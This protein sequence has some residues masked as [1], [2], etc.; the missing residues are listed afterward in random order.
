M[1]NAIVTILKNTN[2]KLK[3][4]IEWGDCDDPIPPAW[5][6]R[7]IAGLTGLFMDGI[8]YYTDTDM[9][10][11]A[12]AQGDLIAGWKDP[13]T[14]LSMLQSSPGHRLKL[15]LDSAN[16]RQSIAADQ[17]INYQGF[18]AP[19]G[20]NFNR[21][22][23]TLWAVIRPNNIG[24]QGYAF[25]NIGADIGDFLVTTG[26]AQPPRINLFLTG[27]NVGDTPLRWSCDPILVVVSCGESNATAYVD[28]LSFTSQNPFGAG[29]VTSGPIFYR[30]DLGYALKAE[31]HSMGILDSQISASDLAL[32]R[33][34][35]Y[36]RY[37]RAA[38]TKNLVTQGDSLTAGQNT[39]LGKNWPCL[40]VDNYLPAGWRLWNQAVSGTTCNTVK[41]S[42]E[43][44][45]SV[46]WDAAMSKN[47]YVHALGLNDFA[48]LNH[49]AAQALADADICLS[50][51]REARFKTVVSTIADISGSSVWDTTKEENRLLYNAALRSGGSL[52]SKV[53]VLADVSAN[54]LLDD[55]LNATY[56]AADKIHYTQAGSDLLASAIF[57][58][59]ISAA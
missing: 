1:G 57:G 43:S 40:A 37:R 55:P 2:K 41:D 25:W 50:A 53:D 33:M 22:N 6:P 16:G 10:T 4:K 3:I 13:V 11:P 19:T 29:D 56:R 42:I 7:Q 36:A 32:L 14:G 47:V 35:A 31:I 28:D 9:T 46:L 27:P 18:I 49:T 48:L 20:Y 34:W 26:Q 12:A 58:P 21:R 17:D 8:G 51:M 38:P 23:C 24:F 30:Q 52:A 5:E 45:S 39:V 59:A 44:G 15:R 54:T